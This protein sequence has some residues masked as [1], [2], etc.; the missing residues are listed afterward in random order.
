MTNEKVRI[1]LIY[2]LIPLTIIKFLLFNGLL[3]LTFYQLAIGVFPKIPLFL[4]SVASIIHI[5]IKYEL[6]KILS[7][8]ALSQN[9]DDI[10]DSF[11]KEALMA[12][13]LKSS[14]KSQISYLLKFTQ[15][16]FFLEKA[17]IDGK[18]LKMID[19][20]KADLI[21]KAL[22]IAKKVNG[23]YLTTADLF[24]A[25]LLL[26]EN[27]TKLLFT[28]KL[29]EEDIL[30][31]NKWARIIFEEEEIRETKARFVGIGFGETLAWGW[32]PETKN[33]TKDLTFSSIKRK[34]FV[35]G[36]E[37]EYQVL[38]EAMQKEADN[39][40]LLV[41][42]IGTGKSNLVE[43]FIFDSY[44]ANLSKTLN[45]RRFLEL[46]IGPFVAGAT[47]RE[48]LETRLQA[49][50]E[51]VK[52]SG[53]VV[54]YI[55]EFQNLMGSSA[56]GI[57]L[58]GAILPYLKDGKMPIIATMT[59]P[60]YKRF[61]ENNALRQVFEVIKLE[62]PSPE[63]ALNMLFQKTEEIEKQ[64]KVKLSYKA[65]VAA[66]KYADKYDVNGVLPGSAV[67]LLSEAANS[68]YL[69]KSRD[70][71][72]L[73]DDVLGKVEQKSHIPIGAPKSDEKK[74]LL[75]LE[76]E[77]HK[78]I[79][80]QN[81]AVAS[82]AEAMR[83]IRAGL[84]REKPISFLFLGPTG[85]GKTETAKTLAR[86][87]FGGEAHIIRV[88]MS[89]YGNPDS[90]DRML[91]S[92]SGSFLDAV[93]THPFSL[94]L[95]DE[96]EKANEKI[97]NLFLQVFDDGRMTD[98]S[99]RTVSFSNSIIIATSNAGSELIRESLVNNTNITSN[100]LLDYL[101]RN[102]LFT[103]ELLN[104]FDDIVVF[105][106]LSSSEVSQIA[107]LL[108][109]EV[110]SKMSAQD[111][112]IEFDPSTVNKVV[113]GGFNEQFGARPLRRFIQDNIEDALAKKILS[114][115]LARGDKVLVS[116]DPASNLVIN[117]AP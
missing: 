94:V 83:R 107:Q 90:V 53:N 95:L 3:I 8:K 43:N 41:G 71:I 36:R 101:Q 96:F 21:N 46:M 4:L 109:A 29:K 56:F 54:L 5:F 99:G 74:L 31:I 26:T 92:D 81:E 35:E 76:S 82:I 22:E 106:P 30:S 112:A 68:V 69:N 103:P 34:A 84:S 13:L 85:V 55:P 102:G 97:L 113:S 25:Y 87:Y 67:E 78:F 11:T 37:T 24:S 61:F 88:D 80:G 79:I 62:E 98:S 117:K 44:E 77:M 42:E 2:N 38:I 27:E 114:G 17:A 28:N 19:I 15:T 7:Q 100:E 63:V 116:I 49:I 89:E 70:K 52:H 60:E 33:Y 18:N 72:V 115:E 75:N 20:P 45:H 51:E 12:T 104:R 65:L 110:T 40:V 91:E 57:D 32:T 111:I 9:P 93:A 73:E 6:E 1:A 14:T 10:L 58:S 48:D 86:I 59:E 64:N 105:Q 66:V 39:N 108:L 23:K 47:N 16:K 50:I